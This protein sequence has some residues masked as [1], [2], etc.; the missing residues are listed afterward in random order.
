MYVVVSENVFYFRHG[1]DGRRRCS[2]S[3]AKRYSRSLRREEYG[4][5]R[6]R[7]FTFS[8][9]CPTRRQGEQTKQIKSEG[10]KNNRNNNNP[11]P[12]L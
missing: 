12:Y 9:F 10:K 3:L 4:A 6:A 1:D 2:S 8:L 11:L 7:Q 5:A